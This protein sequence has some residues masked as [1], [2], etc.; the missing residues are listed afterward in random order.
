MKNGQSIDNRAFTFPFYN[1]RKL[2]VVVAA[3][4]ILMVSDISLIRIYD[5]MS[6]QLISTET[7]ETLFAFITISCLVAEYILL[8]FIKPLHNKNKSENKLHV[9][10]LYII[11][12]AMQYLI[13]AIVVLLILQILFSSKYSNIVLLAIILFSYVLSIGILSAL[14]IRILTL[15]PPKRNTVFMML[16]VF[17]LGCITINAAITM[18]NVSLRIGDRQ[19]ETVPFFGGSGD[20]GKGR[21]NTIDDLYFISYIL[22]FVSAWVATATLLSNYANKLGKIKYMLITISPLIFFIGQFVAS[23]TNGISSIINID[24]FFL[25]SY[26]TIIVTLSKPLG[27][28]ML[29]IGFWSMAKVGK[30]N[31]S[32]KM[33]LIISGFGFF[34]LFTSNQAILMSIVP[35]PPFGIATITVMGL[36]AYLV[37]IGIY[38][39]TISLSQD[40]ELRRSIRRT[41]RTQ[42]K[43]FDSMVTAE[44]ER[45]IE[46][47]VMQV[48]RTQS[49]EMENETGVQP[50]LNDQEIKDYLRQVI[51]EVKR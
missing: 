36:S 13:G 23:F 37:V 16:F 1:N 31:S 49:T 19:P 33:Y 50:S 2:L 38:M 15:L 40:A 43:L 26:T 9:N 46:K 8:E 30:S 7:K 14:I 11:T 18:V 41:A 42:S 20:L 12:K 45:E 5:I 29:G 3:L 17:A 32:L 44:I 34:L 4:I 28:L 27:G 35:Y 21:Y 48:I 25:A 47:R 22:S 10:L 24:R 39:S 6:K 51:K